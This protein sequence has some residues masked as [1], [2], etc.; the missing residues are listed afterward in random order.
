[1]VNW[2]INDFN[3]VKDNYPKH[4]RR[5]EKEYNVVVLPWPLQS[6]DCN[7]IENLWTIILNKI[8]NKTF[9]NKDLK[10]VIMEENPNIIMP[11]TSFVI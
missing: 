5:F 4:T 3:F 2:K 6:P 8:G 7:P 1:M 9:N 11:K 10:H